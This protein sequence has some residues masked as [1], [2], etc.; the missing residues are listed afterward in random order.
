MSVFGVPPE[1]WRVDAA[2][3]D[4]YFLA[5]KVVVGTV[6]DWGFKPEHKPMP[7]MEGIA[8]VYLFRH[9]LELALKHILFH[10]RLA[11]DGAR[12]E[13]EAP[14]F[15]AKASSADGAMIDPARRWSPC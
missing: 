14:R 11:A 15:L 7:A 12:H 1:S 3:A 8:G 6:V 13:R 10:S 4:G 9:Y 2:W 5:A